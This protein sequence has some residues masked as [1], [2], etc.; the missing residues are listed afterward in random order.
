MNWTTF[1]THNEAPEKAFETLCNQLFENWCKEEYSSQIKFF[2]IVNGSGGDGGVESYATLVDDSVVG[3]QAKWFPSSMTA[4]QINQI[5][6]SI[7]TAVKKRPKVK[8]YIV[9]V[10]RYLASLT[11]KGENTE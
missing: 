9:C 10:P 7:K 4:S 2:N 6:N 1:Q 11:G 5:K 3:L 8:G